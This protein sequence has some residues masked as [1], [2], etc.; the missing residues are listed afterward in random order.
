M[1]KTLGYLDR[2]GS[3]RNQNVWEFPF[4]L[5]WTLSI[6]AIMHSVHNTLKA[7]IKPLKTCARKMSYS[8]TSVR[9]MR[10]ALC[11]LARGK[12]IYLLVLILNENLIVLIYKNHDFSKKSEKTSKLP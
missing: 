6:I 5:L 1:E 2:N 11:L 9:W 12:S 3:T 10:G 8:E 7:S 4:N